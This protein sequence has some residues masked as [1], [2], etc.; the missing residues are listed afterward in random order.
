M[1]ISRRNAITGTNPYCWTLKGR[2][3]IAPTYL[4]TT[5]EWLPAVMCDNVTD[6]R[7]NGVWSVFFI[8]GVGSLLPWNFFMNAKQVDKYGLPW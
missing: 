2:T 4:Q 7:W 1:K 6:C 5:L 3:G 8:L